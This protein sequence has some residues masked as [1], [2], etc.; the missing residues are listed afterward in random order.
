MAKTARIIT[1]LSAVILCF[2]VGCSKRSFLPEP[3][4]GTR[5][6]RGEVDASIQQFSEDSAG[7]VWMRTSSDGL[8]RAKGQTVLHYLADPEDSGSLSS[9]SAIALEVSPRGDVWVGTD[10]GID[11]FDEQYNSFVHYDV[12]SYDSYI[13]GIL[14]DAEGQVYA[15]SWRSLF[16]LDEQTGTFQ[17]LLDFRAVTTEEAR[18]FFDGNGRLWVNYSDLLIRFSAQLERD[19][20]LTPGSN[21]RT[22]LPFGDRILVLERDGDLRSLDIVSGADVPLPASLAG[23]SGRS[24]ASMSRMSDGTF[25]FRTGQGRMI[26]D[27]ETDALQADWIGPS[28]YDPILSG[29]AGSAFLLDEYDNLWFSVEDGGYRVVKVD[30]V[31]EMSHP[32]LLTWLRGKEWVSTAT[33]GHFFWLLLSGNSLLTYDLAGKDIVDVSLLQDLLGEAFAAQQLHTDGNGRLLVSGWGRNSNVV[34]TL[35]I[36]GQGHPSLESRYTA[37]EGIAAAFDVEGGV[38]AF[39]VGSHF[40]YGPK[41]QPGQ[42]EV[43]MIPIRELPQ[44]NEIS[45]GVKSLMLRDGRIVMGPTNNNPILL[46][47]SGPAVREI[48]V[49]KDRFQVFW[50]IFFQDSRGDIWL[51]SR[52]AGLY[53]YILSEDRVEAILPNDQTGVTN[54]GE[55]ASGRV[56][57]QC[58]DRRVLRWD[59]AEGQMQLLWSD[60]ERRTSERWMLALPNGEMYLNDGQNIFPL[61]SGVDEQEDLSQMPLMVTIASKDRVITSISTLVDDGSHQR[62]TW[63]RSLQM[64]PDLFLSVGLPGL[65][66]TYDYHLRVNS[67]ADF[68]RVSSL[69]SE[70]SLHSLRYG[71]NRIRFQV[72]RPDTAI[73]SPEYSLLLYVRRPFWHWLALAGILGVLTLLGWQSY[74]LFRRREEVRRERKEREMLERLNQGNIDFFSN[75]SHEFRAP[76]TLVNAAL[77]SIGDATGPAEIERNTAMA[78]RSVSR[79]LNLVSQLMDY[80]KLDHGKLQLSVAPCDLSALIRKSWEVF[81]VGARQKNV[82]FRI[83][84]SE[85]SPIGW[86]DADKVE[87]ILWNFCSNALKFTPPGGEI[88]LDWSCQDDRLTV[89]VLDTGIGLEEEKIP[90]LFER[91][92]QS[93]KAKQTGGTGIGLFYAKAL[94]EL[95]HGTISGFNRQDGP[96]AEFTFSIPVGEQAYSAEEKSPEVDPRITAIAGSA[97]L[98]VPEEAEMSEKKEALPSVLVIDDDYELVYYL[99]SLLSKDYNV[100]FRFDAMSGYNLIR[101]EAPDVVICDVMMMDVSGLEL[102]RMV[103]EN[104]DLCHIPVVMLTARSSVGDQVNALGVGADAYVTK[105]FEPD[106]LTALV[107][108][109]IDNRQRLRN[110]LSSSTMTET[111][112][113]PDGLNPR[114]R[115]F[116]DKVYENLEDSLSTGEIDIDTIAANIGVSRSKFFYKIKALTGQTPGDFFT[117]YKLNRA[118]Q[119]LRE[120]KYKISAVASMVG[121]SSSSHF[122]SLF[123]K[124]FGVLPSQYIQ[125]SENAE[126]N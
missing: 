108:S 49:R 26:Y 96:G 9:N 65:G 64:I 125:Q 43:A 58:F 42:R 68:T 116:M 101:Q 3:K 81:Q 28:P 126:E 103:K 87:K 118:A 66:H 120:D 38:W 40:Y 111:Q 46:D 77:D 67:S 8:Y 114:D 90:H 25:S 91:F 30:P 78:R 5:V 113:V 41:S 47:P 71:R 57:F 31:G 7:T 44:V 63:L 119:L 89:R 69:S 24:I 29:Q 48:P 98:I 17:T 80:N 82:D 2:S 19:L 99:K 53:R 70:T 23:L 75:I 33:D 59:P 45:Y 27:K 115:A 94:A 54:I 55:D 36:D 1:A 83:N 20:V 62:K 74:S 10:R 95:H 34:W 60:E 13:R 102:C 100:S 14:F 11:R 107:R 88:D 122:A 73:G 39:G 123:K 76:L 16:K 109:V 72:N 97:S 15:R 61:T 104:P 84:G 93:A 51:G 86:V 124:R 106:Y 79:M 18:P 85:D 12:D 4:E 6:V 32:S 21:L 35:R 52:T 105:P 56:I 37:P 92:N 22:V 110:F 121:F 50:N 117:L 112:D